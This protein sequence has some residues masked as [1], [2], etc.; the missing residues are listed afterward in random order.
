M[1]DTM[2]AWR[3]H[4]P[5]PMP[6]D[7]CVRTRAGARTRRRRRVGEGARVRRV[8][9]RPARR[10]GRPP[11]APAPVVPGHEVVGEVVAVGGAV[12]GRG[13]RRVGVAWLRHT[14]GSVPTAVAGRENLCPDSR[15][16]GWD[17]D[18]GYAEYAV[19]P[20]AYGPAA[21]RLPDEQIA[22]LLCA[23]IIGYR[24]LARAELPGAGGSASTA[25]AAAP[26]SP[27]RSRWRGA[28]RCT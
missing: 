18:G 9:D 25:S 12:A 8:P 11:G 27:H 23:G 4:S 21:R 1:Q 17:A 20:A 10:R 13:G 24:A 15:Y 26:T 7:R 5:G 19:V 16:T 3:V 22:P 28:P 14:C 6:A 2:A